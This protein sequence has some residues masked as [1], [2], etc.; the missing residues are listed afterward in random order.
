MYRF[1]DTTLNNGA[2]NMA[3]DEALLLGQANYGLPPAVRIYQFDPATLSIGY[4]QRIE[5]EVDI[6]YC[7]RRGF[8]IVR[9]PT[10]GRAVLHDKELT[11][12]ITIAYPHRILE[13]NLLD[14]FHFLSNGIIKAIEV[15]GGKAYFSRREDNE[16]NSSSCFAAPTFSDILIDGKK[17][18]GSAQMRNKFGLIQHG[19]I[20]YDVNLNDIFHCIKIEDSQRDKIIS[21]A[22]NKITSL[23]S[24]LKRKV[25]LDE[26]KRAFK[27]GMQDV[28][29]EEFVDS[30]MDERELKMAQR[31]FEEKYNTHEWNF[32]R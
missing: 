13:M 28:L 4:F 15:L 20:L 25:T 22:S 10:G 21:L 6:D 3:I 12:S 8:D 24:E 16:I 1:I 31:L 14:S 9:R 26:L 5:K 19:S 32:K 7:K 30:S 29:Q 2:M 17:V 23:N 18:V 27:I 11:Y